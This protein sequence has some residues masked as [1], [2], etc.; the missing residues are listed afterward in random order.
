MPIKYKIAGQYQLDE[1]YVHKLGFTLAPDAIVATEWLKLEG[2]HL[3]IKAG[4]SWDGPSGPPKWLSG[5][6]GVGAVYDKIMLP[7][8]M[9]GSLIH[10]AGY[11]LIRN[12]LI[13]ES[14]RSAWDNE[15]IR[16]CK[17]DGMSD[18]RAWWVHRGVRKFGGP[19]ARAGKTR[20]VYSAP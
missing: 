1:G 19:G 10:D 17:Q 3:S 18:I 2:N 13:P 6:P 16:V 12:E 15:L 5:I 8:I 20:P 9:R 14:S 7:K 4:Y 11:Q